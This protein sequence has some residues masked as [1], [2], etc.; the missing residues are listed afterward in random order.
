MRLY[1]LFPLLAGP[2][3]QAAA[4]P[5]HTSTIARSSVSDMVSSSTDGFS[6]R[7]ATSCGKYRRIVV[8]RLKTA[9]GASIFSSSW[10]RAVAS[11]SPW[12]ARLAP[13]RLPLASGAAAV[14]GA[15]KLRVW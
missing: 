7:P 6:W 15:E 8:G 4:D 10:I 9:E 3:V 14:L 12:A 13:K 5:A 11:R 1:N 2:F